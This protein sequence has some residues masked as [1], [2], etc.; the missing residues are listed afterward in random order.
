MKAKQLS[1][2]I[3]D[4]YTELRMDREKK[5]AKRR[6]EDHDWGGC[7]RTTTT[8]KMACDLRDEAVEVLR[9]IVFRKMEQEDIPMEYFESGGI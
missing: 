5:K 3:P 4:I 7:Y 6:W 8:G 1:F 2:A 9:K